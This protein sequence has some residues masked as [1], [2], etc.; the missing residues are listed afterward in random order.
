MNQRNLYIHFCASG[1]VPEDSFYKNNKVDG[2]SKLLLKYFYT[3]SSKDLLESI[4]M[5]NNQSKITNKHP[6]ESMEMHLE[7][8]LVRGCAISDEGK[9][10][11]YNFAFPE[12]SKVAEKLA[13]LA[14]NPDDTDDTDENAFV[15]EKD[16]DLKNLY[17]NNNSSES[18]KFEE[19]ALIEESER[20]IKFES[21]MSEDHLTNIVK[22]DNIFISGASRGFFK[23]IFFINSL[24]Q[25]LNT[26]GY[27]N[28][29]QFLQKIHLF[30]LDPVPG[31][32][33][34]GYVGSTMIDIDNIT[35]KGEKTLS[36]LPIKF[37]SYLVGSYNAGFGMSRSLPKT[38]VKT[39]CDI[40]I[41][42]NNSSNC[43]MNDLSI[44]SMTQSEYV[45]H[46]SYIHLNLDIIVHLFKYMLYFTSRGP[47]F[48]SFAFIPILE[49]PLNALPA[50][51]GDENELKNSIPSKELKRVQKV[52]NDNIYIGLRMMY[53]I[54]DK[55]SLFLKK[56]LFVEDK[57]GYTSNKKKF[58]DD[59]SYIVG[60]KKN[61]LDDYDEIITS[62]LN[63]SVNLSDRIINHLYGKYNEPY[64]EE[65]AEEDYKMMEDTN[66]NIM[67][68]TNLSND[69]LS[70]FASTGSNYK[71]NL[72]FK[73]K[74]DKYKKENM[75][76][77]KDLTKSL[78]NAIKKQLDSHPHPIFQDRY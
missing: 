6:C 61:L 66:Y 34:M 33:K 4:F 14:C 24:K 45:S 56:I 18:F 31:N 39:I 10:N 52:G 13:K 30:G 47:Y 75:S 8:F 65:K 48:L 22:Y 12:I 28:I 7:S 1:F 16:V 5:G 67:I 26:Q 73:E 62:F 44:N 68:K 2:E 15:I 38:N 36:S 3:M 43:S 57:L 77:L 21:V 35:R 49:Q 9:L 42:N 59:R 40:T 17:S 53:P 55:Y 64:D 69:C 60:L 27:E 70:T 23:A 41:A 29:D 11:Y 46:N 20:N 37:V 32:T 58:I 50:L 72:E 74:L 78:N 71:T 51:I 76:K 54:F 63:Y 19:L 25:V